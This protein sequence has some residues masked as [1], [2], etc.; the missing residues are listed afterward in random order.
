M[1]TVLKLTSQTCA[2]FP[3]SQKLLTGSLFGCNF[4]F[5]KS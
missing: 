5:E 2:H 1:V 4:L 3:K